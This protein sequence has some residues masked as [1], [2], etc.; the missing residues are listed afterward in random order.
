MDRSSRQK[1]N[2]ETQTL[3]DTTDQIDLIAIYRTFWGFP[4]GSDSKESACSVGDLG[5]IPGLERCPEGGHG[6]PLQYS[7]LENPYGQRRLVGWSPWGREES[8]TPEQLSPAQQR[9]NQ[10]QP[11]REGWRSELEDKMVVITVEGQNREKE[12]KELRTDSETSGTHLTHQN[13]K[14]RKEEEKESK[15]IFEV[16]TVTQV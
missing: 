6:N 11:N 2:I 14:C 5:S 12:W 7:C 13:L 4:G 1:I 8:G 10:K 3:N 15:K 16:I 9:R